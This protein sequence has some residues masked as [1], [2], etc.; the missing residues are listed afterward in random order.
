MHLRRRHQQSEA[1]PF[2]S[3]RKKCTCSRP[4]LQSVRQQALDRPSSS[5]AAL[6]NLISQCWS[7]RVVSRS[8][9]FHQESNCSDEAAPR[10]LSPSRT[11][12]KS[13]HFLSQFAKGQSWGAPR[14][15]RAIITTLF[16]DSRRRKRWL[17]NWKTLATGLC[18]SGA[19]RQRREHCCTIFQR[20]LVTKLG[21]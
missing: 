15:S 12:N 16:I 7:F 20:V 17:C 13:V 9:C 2:C 21:L 6:G 1:N 8:V 5:W 19:V 3:H 14:V 4:S 10:Q 18:T 11:A